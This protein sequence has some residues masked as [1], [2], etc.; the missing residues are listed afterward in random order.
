MRIRRTGPRPATA[1]H[2]LPNASAR[3]VI[4]ATARCRPPGQPTAPLVGGNIG[5]CAV[6]TESF[7]LDMNR[8]R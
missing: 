2:F 4:L 6:F 5:S 1:S 3:T 7:G 8:V